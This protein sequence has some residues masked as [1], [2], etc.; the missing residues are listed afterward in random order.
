MPLKN[1]E[2]EEGQVPSD[3]TTQTPKSRGLSGQKLGNRRVRAVRARTC[4]VYACR[5]SVTCIPYDSQCS[6]G[7]LLL[8]AEYANFMA[9]MRRSRQKRI[10]D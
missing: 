8:Q 6:Y 4:W 5:M 10:N 3:K 1:G 9:R 7:K 2:N